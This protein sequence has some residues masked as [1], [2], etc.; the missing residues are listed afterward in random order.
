MFTDVLFAIAWF[1]ATCTDTSVSLSKALVASSIAQVKIFKA[2][3]NL[4]AKCVD[5]E[6][7][8]E[9]L[10]LSAFLLRLIVHPFVPLSSQN[11]FLFFLLPI[12]LLFLP[13]FSQFLELP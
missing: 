2:K 3:P 1:I 10:Q 8:L 5:F 7:L 13:F 6:L 11:P 12:F 4:A 9:Q